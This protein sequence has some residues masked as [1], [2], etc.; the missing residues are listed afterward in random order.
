MALPPSLPSS[1]NATPAL[2]PTS[3]PSATPA[4]ASTSRSP[5]SPEAAPF[6]PG[7]TTG[8]PKELRWK[9]V[10]LSP[11]SC[12]LA[13]SADGSPTPFLDALLRQPSPSPA[14]PSPARSQAAAGPPTQVCPSA[15][16]TRANSSRAVDHAPVPR[17]AGRC[18]APLRRPRPAR[19]RLHLVHGLPL[20]GR[21][22]YND[23][24][25][26]REEQRRPVH[27]RLGPRSHK[28][29]SPPDAE[30]WQEVLPR[31]GQVGG[32]GQRAS[33]RDLP[34]PSRIPAEL[35]GRCLN[36][37]SFGHKVATCRLPTRYL[38]CHRF[39]HVAKQCTQP[40]TSPEARRPPV[41]G[42]SGSR[43][44]VRA[45]RDSPPIPRGS[46]A[47][48]LTPSPPP[49]GRVPHKE[50][51]SRRRQSPPRDAAT[52]HR[53]AAPEVR[54]HTPRSFARTGRRG[55]DGYSSTPSPPTPVRVVDRDVAA[56]QV[57]CSFGWSLQLPIRFGRL[58]PKTIPGPP[59]LHGCGAGARH[60]RSPEV[61]TEGPVLSSPARPVPLPDRA[62]DH[63]LACPSSPMLK[64]FEPMMFELAGQRVASVGSS[65]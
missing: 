52:A 24:H 47:V 16:Q 42:A 57:A 39:R 17:L 32:R 23:R 45:R 1:A 55:P 54:G 5:L 56:R 4:P 53:H 21:V 11:I 25:A 41:R 30:G 34:E 49:A 35:V 44:F 59:V 38:R 15:A 37:L 20:R 33:P 26:R 48:G 6:Y 64:T 3:I 10:S 12:F 13:A 62:A 22:V 40:R 19:P 36:C 65:R 63:V 51:N 8:R 18:D 2:P 58:S 43:C 50:G 60:P 7:G 28:R 31:P 61:S 29:S 27:Q 14:G 46:S 9:D